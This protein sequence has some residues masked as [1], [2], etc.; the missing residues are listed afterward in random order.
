MYSE[1]MYT[2]LSPFHIQYVPIFYMKY[3][4]SSLVL[5]D[6]HYI[7][8]PPTKCINFPTLHTW[9]LSNPNYKIKKAIKFETN[10]YYSPLTTLL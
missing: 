1:Y 3:T 7:K 5:V 2:F 6:I 8:M 10:V 9:R 4:V